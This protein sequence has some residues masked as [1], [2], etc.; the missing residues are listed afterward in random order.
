MD[1]PKPQNE[2]EQSI[3]AN[4]TDMIAKE[5]EQR[6]VASAADVLVAK[7]LRSDKTLASARQYDCER[8]F[9]PRYQS[10]GIAITDCVC[11]HPKHWHY[12]QK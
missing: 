1:T 6:I 11:G 3:V 4:A 2:K 5:L 8:C 10:K 9:C 7:L 12:S